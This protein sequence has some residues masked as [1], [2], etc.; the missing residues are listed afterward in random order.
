MNFVS[1]LETL[2]LAIAVMLA[3][4]F[5]TS[6]IPLCSA[7]DQ[8]QK[9]SQMTCASVYIFPRKENGQSVSVLQSRTLVVIVGVGVGYV[10]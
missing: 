7:T 1:L 6:G 3:K 10:Q 5:F 8:D 9:G 2:V 4:L